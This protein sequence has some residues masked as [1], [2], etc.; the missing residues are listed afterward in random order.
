MSPPRP[1]STS[2][3]VFLGLTRAAGIAILA[4]FATLV[5]VLLRD[6]WPVLSR[7]GTYQLFTS[8]NWNSSPPAPPT[9]TEEAVASVA[10]LPFRFKKGKGRF[11]I[12]HV[13]SRRHR[14]H[15]PNRRAGQNTHIGEGMTEY[16]LDGKRVG[17]GLSEYLDQNA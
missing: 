4:L 5:A 7:A 11:H 2:E 1:A 13:I 9:P 17:F 8:A 16:T 10:G 6:S 12:L 14:D 15:R 3:F